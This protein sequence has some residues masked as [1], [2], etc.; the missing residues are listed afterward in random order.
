MAGKGAAL[1]DGL[2]APAA[3]ERAGGVGAAG[4]A[5][6]AASGRAYTSIWPLG[7]ARRSP[8]GPGSRKAASIAS[9]TAAA[10][11]ALVARGQAG[12]IGIKCE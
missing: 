9:V 4:A 12:L 5:P 8:E 7:V 1:A 11:S 3:V 6:T 2:I 10:S